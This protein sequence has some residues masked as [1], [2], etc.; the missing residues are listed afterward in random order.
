MA[1]PGVKLAGK[2]IMSRK[3]L[4]LDIR[5]DALCAVMLESGFKGSRVQ[6]HARIPLSGDGEPEERLEAGLE[7]L[8]RQMDL[9]D[10]F[11]VAALPADQ[12][13]YRNLRL[14]FKDAKKIRQVLPFELESTLPV[15]V[16]SLIIDFQPL[17][18]PPAQ[19]NGNAE[20]TDVLAASVEIETL[21]RYF[22]PL[23]AYRIKP[24]LFTVG[25]YLTARCLSRFA[26]EM[27]EEWLLADIQG[28]K[29]TFF[30]I[31]GGQV[32][33]I[34]AFR[35]GRDLRLAPHVHRTLAAAEQMF[36][37]EVAPMEIWLTGS[38]AG[39][40]EKELAEAFDVPIRLSHLIEDSHGRIRNLPDARWEALE[41]DN[42]LSLALAE[43]QGVN[44]ALNFCRGPFAS[45]RQWAEYKGHLIK[46]G[47]LAGLVLLILLAN[48][49]FQFRAKERMLADLD[50]QI[51][52]VFTQTFPGKPMVQPAHQMKVALDAVRE[53]RQVPDIEGPG[54]L[55]ILNAMS[56]K[57]PADIDVIFTR[58]VIGETDIQI[59]GETDS[60]DAV[61]TVRNRLE[62]IDW[63]S[64]VTIVTTRFEKERVSFKL[65]INRRA[66]QEQ[67]S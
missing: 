37:T 23:A 50:A 64:K 60:V 55:D 65:R 33:L 29:G 34:R 6:S 28:K 18:P 53:Q 57:L 24:E 9:S 20:E 1:V 12:V 38:G 10:C 27:P 17:G 21:G 3:I 43:S 48:V 62:T 31:K 16:D 19:S 46:S 22:Q 14:P 8:A 36:K 63:F 13:S 42:A 26:G 32:A 51:A 45:G 11:C 44:G 2:R 40:Y 25:G 30:V 56:R 61:D 5:P 52:A 58:L 39:G 67:S 59:N 47:I 7:R 4:G 15:P 35:L 49:L 54:V 66:S 41:M